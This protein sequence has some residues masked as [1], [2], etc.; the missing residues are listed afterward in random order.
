VARTVP[1][2]PDQGPAEGFAAMTTQRDLLRED[3]RF[4]ILRLLQEN[5]EMSQRELA[6]T[7]GASSG[8]IHYVLAALVERGMVKLSNFTTA[9]DKRRYAYVLTPQGLAEKTRLA[10]GFVQRKLAEYA[11][12]KAE[13][14]AVG[15]D[16]PADELARIRAELDRTLPAP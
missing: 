3:V 4:R 9:A 7:V 15:A 12:L 5:P 1:T 14:D 2:D 16:L 11:A 6:R 10:R 13:I 8:G